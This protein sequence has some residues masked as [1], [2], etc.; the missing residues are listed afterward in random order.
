MI[1][2]A[3]SD[4]FKS[5]PLREVMNDGPSDNGPVAH[6]GYAAQSFAEC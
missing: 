4:V 1:Y 3:H 2:F 5:N 6:L